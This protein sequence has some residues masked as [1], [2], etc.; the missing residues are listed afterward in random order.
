MPAVVFVP[1][2]GSVA[3]VLAAMVV[4]VEVPVAV[5]LAAQEELAPTSEVV[6]ELEPESVESVDSVE[7]VELEVTVVLEVAVVLAST[8]A[9]PQSVALVSATVSFVAS[10]VGGV[11]LAT[12][13]ESVVSVESVALAESVVAVVL[14]TGGASA[15][16][17]LVLVLGSVLPPPWFVAPPWFDVGE[18]ALVLPFPAFAAIL[19]AISPSRHFSPLRRVHSWSSPLCR[20]STRALWLLLL[21]APEVF[22]VSAVLAVLAMA[23]L[24]PAVVLPE[25]PPVTP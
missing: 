22:A 12:V 16:V 1:A 14:T 19:S 17:V 9:D 3:V 11:R 13:E 25:E 15:A 10:G 7:S 5:V 23:V 20:S 24:F 4:P 8:V 21:A 2:S 6:L 18:V